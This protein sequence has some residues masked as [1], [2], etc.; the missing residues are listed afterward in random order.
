MDLL[1]DAVAALRTGRPHSNLVRHSSPY[2][3]SFPAA[4]SAGFH[5]VLQGSCALTVAA[6]PEITLAAGDVAFLPW[7][8]AHGL[9]GAATVL[10]CGAYLQN[11]SRIH[12]LLADLPEVVHLPAAVGRQSELRAAIDLLGAELQHPRPGTDAMI[13][14]LL[15]IVL[16]HILR[17]WSAEAG[18]GWA[19]ALRDP[20]VAAA[21]H[22]IHGDVGRPWTVAELAAEAG[23]SRAA[24]AR[25]F[26]ALIGRPPLAYLTWWRMTVAAGL[27]REGDAPLAAVAR[28]VGY[29][30]E[31]AFAHA[32]KRVL[33]VAPGAYRTQERRASA[34]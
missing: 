17:A 2:R 4:D 12:P 6:E 20:A 29:G 11:R 34:G 3:S 30:S 14:P 15:E 24:L 8:A 26:G 19:T 9:S 25:R 21:L 13:P 27:L 32:F 33:G 16:L 22:A 28:R 5:V 31:Y 10:L 18:T 1:S 7:G 23:L